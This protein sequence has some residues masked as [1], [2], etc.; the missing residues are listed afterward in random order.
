VDCRG[1]NPADEEGMGPIEYFPKSRGFPSYYFPFEN[2]EAYESPLVAVQVSIFRVS[3]G[4]NVS[5]QMHIV[6]FYTNCHAYKPNRQK[7]VSQ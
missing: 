6:E 2:Q 1:E 3:F 7:F 4:Q 5:G